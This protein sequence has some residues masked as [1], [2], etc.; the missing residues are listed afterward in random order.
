M[1]KRVFKQIDPDYELKINEDI[2]YMT[3]LQE[4]KIIL[5]TKTYLMIYDIF[6]KKFLLKKE[7]NSNIFFNT[8]QIY[9]NNKFILFIN[10]SDK[11]Q[12][13][14]FFEFIKNNNNYYLNN[15]G[16]INDY[17][18]HILIYKNN[19]IIS[20]D[21]HINIYTYS[22]NK[23]F[24]LQTKLFFTGDKNKVIIHPN[25]KSLGLFHKNDK[26][27]L[28]LCELDNNYEIIHASKIRGMDEINSCDLINLTY[29]LIKYN[30]FFICNHFSLYLYSSSTLQLIKKN[31]IWL[32]NIYVN[33]LL[34]T[35]NGDIYGN[36]G[37]N[38]Y[39]YNFENDNFIS[40][41]VCLGRKTFISLLNIFEKKEKKIIIKAFNQ[42]L[43]FYTYNNIN[44]IK[45]HIK[46]YCIFLLLSLIF[47]KLIF[48]YISFSILFILHI[49]F[50]FGLRYD[51][52]YHLWPKSER[53]QKALIELF[54]WIGIL[55]SIY[56][57]ILKNYGLFGLI[58]TIILGILIIIFMLPKIVMA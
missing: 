33:R 21:T 16:I 24:Q 20:Q 47:T 38:V 11:R 58:V 57:A 4:D 19:T 29:K 43:M 37:M 10:C 13:I 31:K 54:F 1:K 52:W 5:I 22:K 56:Y 25:G 51:L 30:K 18:K 14:Y 53:L 50:L 32:N 8:I 36:D 23:L 46:N 2:R 40:D 34:V 6:E 27:E 15:I 9:E 42:K 3:L 12:N 48:G 39:K 28:F 49:A 7:F 41:E 55:V 17:L 26:N 44:V 35:K 45:Y